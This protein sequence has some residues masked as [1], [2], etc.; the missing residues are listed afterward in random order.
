[1]NKYFDIQWLK[2]QIWVWILFGIL[3]M[4]LFFY[5]TKG[6][7]VFI[8]GIFI[9]VYMYNIFGKDNQYRNYSNITE[10]FN[11]FTKNTNNFFKKKWY[12]SSR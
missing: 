11:N 8:G 3:I 7:I 6:L 10:N 12:F 9:G 1:M 2:K 4:S 5:I